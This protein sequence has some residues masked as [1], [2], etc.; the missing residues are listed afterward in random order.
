MISLCTF[1]KNEA[2]C[3]GRMIRSVEDYVDEVVIVDTGSTDNTINVAMCALTRAIPLRI[4]EIG[5]TDFGKI[6]TVTSHLARG[7]YVLMLDADEE[8][9][10][11]EFLPLL[12]EEGNLAYGFPRRRWED[13]KKQQ[14]TELEAFP[15]YQV[16]FYKNNVE[17]RWERELHEYFDGAP[18]VLLDHGPV[19]E[20][21]HDVHKN[22]ERLQ[23]R[24]E[25]YTKLA[26][27]AGVTIEGGHK[28]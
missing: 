20:H 24:R 12:A 23:E 1:V 4:Y 18:V 3:I 10:H 7:D 28:L 15:D 19:I 5:F 21:F 22:P 16:R 26:E 2:H 27:Q 9:S 6:R 8:L 13:L 11:P 25:L 17:Y 14:Q